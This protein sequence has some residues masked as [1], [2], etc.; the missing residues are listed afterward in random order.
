MTDLAALVAL[1]FGH[2]LLAAGMLPVALAIVADIVPAR[3]RGRWLAVIMASHGAAFVV[4]PVIGGALFDLAGYRA[5]FI[6]S[7][8]LAVPALLLVLPFLSES[9]TAKLRNRNALMRMLAAQTHRKLASKLPRP[10]SMFAVLLLAAFTPM[11]VLSFAEPQF[12]FFAF[13]VLDWSTTQVGLILFAYG[14][15]IISMQLLLGGISD[16]RFDRRWV[17][18]VGVT[19]ESAFYWGMTFL[20][21]FPLIFLAAAVSGV[22][23]GLLSPAVSALMLDFAAPHQRAGVMGL[24]SSASA[25]GAVAGPALAFAVSGHVGSTWLFAGAATFVLVVAVIAALGLRAKPAPRLE[26][27]VEAYRLRTMAA[28]ATLRGLVVQSAAARAN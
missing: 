27:E 11:F 1:R 3:Q 4:G 2:G 13:D 24:R 25:F 28:E 6:G 16:S 19:A 20:D 23:H 26:V 8:V 10:V 18:V 12:I 21:S 9:L 7:A 15:S 22:G 5:S 14:F 17:I